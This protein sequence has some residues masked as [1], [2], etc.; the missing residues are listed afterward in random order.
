LANTLFLAY[1]SDR[2]LK[3][4]AVVHFFRRPSPPAPVRWPSVTLIQP[5]TRTVNDLPRALQSRAQL[6]YPAQIDHLFICDAADLVS[7]AA[8]RAWIAAHPEFCANIVLIDSPAG[9]VATKVAKLQAAMPL[10]RGDVICFVDDDILLRPDTLSRLV[11]Y[12]FQPGVGA[13]VGLACYVDWH[14]LG[15]SLMSA[16][17]NANGLLSYIPITYLTNPFTLTG[18]IYALRREMFEA[19]GGFGGMEPLRVDDDHELARRIS[20]AGLVSRQTPMV[21]DVENSLPSL[22]AYRAQMKRWFLFPREA[23]LPDMD[24]KDR[25]L[26]VL[27]SAANLAPPAIALLAL[28]AR[29]GAVWNTLALRLSVMLGV[30]LFLD[31]VY[32]RRQTPLVRLPLVVISELFAPLQILASLQS[33]DSF[34][35]RGQR[36]RMQR[37]GKVTARE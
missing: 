15:S 26:T 9:V 22:A 32:L 21:Y 34:E 11:P 25:Q 5:V 20:H 7:Q 23:M 33:D 24:A 37:G 2:L 30:Y 12:L 28:L 16:F 19:V 3:L 8:C 36:L 35:W 29:R 31:T 4:A 10:A 27:G 1:L 13:A 14:N 18:H 6:V 17:V